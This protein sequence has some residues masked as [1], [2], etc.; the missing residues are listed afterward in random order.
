MADFRKLTTKELYVVLGSLSEQ[1]K[2]DVLIHFYGS[3]EEAF[4]RA[5]KSMGGGG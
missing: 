4:Y 2:E 1:Q 5:L 3:N